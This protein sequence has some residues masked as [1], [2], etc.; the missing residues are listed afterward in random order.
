MKQLNHILTF[1]HAMKLLFFLA[2]IVLGGKI[3]SGAIGISVQESLTYSSYFLGSILLMMILKIYIQYRLNE[4]EKANN[5]IQTLVNSLGEATNLLKQLS[6]KNQTLE[7]YLETSRFDYE[8][9][10]KKHD[11]LDKLFEET[12]H[13]LENERNLNL[14]LKGEIRILQ[15]VEKRFEASTDRFNSLIHDLEGKI[16]TLESDIKSADET[17]AIQRNKISDITNDRDVW[18]KKY[19]S[20]AASASRKGIKLSTLQQTEKSA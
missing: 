1:S 4:V 2:I 9:L 7:E 19:K 18:K 20:I 11:S 16:S 13:H 3:I 14:S 8:T 10:K 6:G 5:R 15:D 17:L 12:T